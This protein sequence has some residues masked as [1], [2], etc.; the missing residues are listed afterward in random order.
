MQSTRFKVCTTST[1]SLWFSINNAPVFATLNPA[2]LFIH[3]ISIETLFGFTA[4][5]H[6]SRTMR[7]G[8]KRLRIAL[9]AHNVRLRSH[10]CPE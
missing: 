9:A 4:I 1:K 5:H 6:P 8:T 7:T 3:I 10:T 2:R